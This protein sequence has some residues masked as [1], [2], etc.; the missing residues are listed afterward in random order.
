M[1]T[2]FYYS[3]YANNIHFHKLGFACSLVLKAS[4]MAYF[5][6][7]ASRSF[8]LA[9]LLVFTKSFAWLVSR[10]VG[11]FT[12]RKQTNYAQ[13]SQANDLP[14]KRETSASRVIYWA[15]KCSRWIITCNRFNAG[16]VATNSIIVGQESVCDVALNRLMKSKLLGAINCH[17][18][19]KEPIHLFLNAAYCHGKTWC[20]FKQRS[21]P[22]VSWSYDFLVKNINLFF[23]LSRFTV[24]L[25]NVAVTIKRSLLTFQAETIV[26]E[27]L[28]KLKPHFNLGY[29]CENCLHS[30]I[31]LWAIPFYRIKCNEGY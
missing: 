12:G 27:L 13:T 4:Q 19:I 7:P 8:S 6:F 17:W 14:C 25:V 20:Q 29:L 23:F 22:Q 10:V 30:N 26:L 18:I 11:L 1:K 5:L 21:K 15:M 2:S 3:Q 31:G 24:M 9:W 28:Y 16:E